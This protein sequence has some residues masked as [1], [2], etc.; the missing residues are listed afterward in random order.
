MSH[1][2]AANAEHY[3]SVENSFGTWTQSS[4]NRNDQGVD[5]NL[6][7]RLRLGFSFKTSQTKMK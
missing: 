3:F 4:L 7:L 5:Y 1:A 2:R 6:I